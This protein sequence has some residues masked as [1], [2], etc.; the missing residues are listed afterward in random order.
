[1]FR[2]VFLAFLVLLTL[3]GAASPSLAQGRYAH[4]GYNSD[5]RPLDGMLPAIRNAY[6]GR[7]YDAEG[8]IPDGMGGLHYR[9]KWMTP[10]GR[11]IWLDADARSGRVIGPARNGWRLGGPPPPPPP[12]AVYGGYGP[13]RGGQFR[14]GVPQ[15]GRYP[16]GANRGAWGARGNGRPHG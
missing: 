6:P 10:D 1:M 13:A 9:I 3:V 4:G 5:V 7:F 14:Y 12:N 15:G 11:I 2:R 8:P 16:G